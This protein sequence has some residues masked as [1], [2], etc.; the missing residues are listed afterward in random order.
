M[1]AESSVQR[2]RVQTSRDVGYQSAIFCTCQDTVIPMLP[3]TYNRTAFQFIFGDGMP[4]FICF[5][6]VIKIM[7]IIY[8]HTYVHVY[9]MGK[10]LVTFLLEYCIIY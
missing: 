4:I 9:R 2:Y 8:I 10:M 7:H 3:G 6:G 1:H 5:H